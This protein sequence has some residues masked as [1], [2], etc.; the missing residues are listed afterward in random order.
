MREDATGVTRDVDASLITVVLSVVDYSVTSS[1]A[2]AAVCIDFMV[3]MTGNF[4][5]ADDDFRTMGEVGRSGH[6]VVTKAVL[7]DGA[8]DWAV[9]PFFK[10]ATDVELGWVVAD[11]AAGSSA[12]VLDFIS[13]LDTVTCRPLTG[14]PF[15]FAGS[16]CK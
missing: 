8:D 9:A 13:W 2:G 4:F 16:S 15:M 12:D 7:S 11:R 10:A 6:I 14:C 3:G 5:V 1:V